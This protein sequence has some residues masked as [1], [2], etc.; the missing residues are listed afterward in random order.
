[1][2]QDFAPDC[3]Y[4]GSWIS[5]EQV[6]AHVGA[7]TDFNCNRCQRAFFYL[8][9]VGVFFSERGKQ[10]TP[11]SDSRIHSGDVQLPLRPLPGADRAI[12][13]DK[14][15]NPAWSTPALG[16]LTELFEE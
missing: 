16:Q 5:V 2:A 15:T 8:K 7:D 14:E 13:D 12:L 1:M 3:P 6:N 10:I 9:D 4:C 11:A